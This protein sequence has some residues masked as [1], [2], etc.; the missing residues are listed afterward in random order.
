[1][2]TIN[3]GGSKDN[4]LNSGS[5]FVID[6]VLAI[7]IHHQYRRDKEGGWGVQLLKRVGVGIRIL[8]CVC[9][10]K[11]SRHSSSLVGE[12]IE[13][14]IVLCS[15]YMLVFAVVNNFDNVVVVWLL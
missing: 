2:E 13:G 7:V 5:F 4:G 8:E 3:C 11:C 1:M 15:I 10:V 6:G 14:C 12:V 9:F